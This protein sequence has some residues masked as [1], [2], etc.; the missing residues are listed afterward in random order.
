MT[1]PTE[2]DVFLA[3]THASGT[4]SHLSAGAVVGA[5]G[6]RT[7]VLGSAGAYLVTS[8]EGEPTPFAV[9]DP[10]PGNEGWLVRGD[11]A[12]PVARVDGGHVDFYRAV[13]RWLL[14]GGPVPVDPRDAVATATVLD[15][16]RASAASGHPVLLEP[17]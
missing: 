14:S 1:T 16:A 10:G 17:A 7:R 11:V 9:L 15:A 8:F 5:P 13:S 3:L 4:I 12:E 6:P 2:D